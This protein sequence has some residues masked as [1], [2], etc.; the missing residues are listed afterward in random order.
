VKLTAQGEQIVAAIKEGLSLMT[1]ARWQEERESAAEAEDMGEWF[2][3]EFAAARA[4]TQGVQWD[5]DGW[6]NALSY[7]VDGS[8]RLGGV[9]FVAK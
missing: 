4:A 8:G 1:P 3:P 2:A 5:F 7:L 9:S 6:E